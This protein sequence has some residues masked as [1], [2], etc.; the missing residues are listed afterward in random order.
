MHQT[1]LADFQM[2]EINQNCCKE[3][4]NFFEKS[5]YVCVSFRLFKRRFKKKKR[6]IFCY[7][8]IES[9]IRK[10]L[11]SGKEKDSWKTRRK[12]KKRKKRF[13][14]MFFDCLFL[15]RSPLFFCLHQS[16][17]REIMKK[18]LLQLILKMVLKVFLWMT[19]R[20]QKCLVFF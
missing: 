11:K 20:V 14:H 4:K 5:N 2:S 19:Q 18:K 7:H 17:G 10:I 8:F 6:T 12:Q 16:S 13:F 9:E 1:L 3:K 15:F